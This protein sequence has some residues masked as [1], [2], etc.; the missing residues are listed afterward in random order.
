MNLFKLKINTEDLGYTMVDNVF[1]NHYMPKAPGDYV[2]VY[3][4]GLKFAV[5]STEDEISN[6]MVSKTLGM[7][8]EAVLGAW[9]YWD[10]Q[11]IIRLHRFNP[12]ALNSSDT[13]YIVEYL[14]LKELVP[15]IKEQAKVD[16]YSPD[17][18]INARQNLKTKE[19]FDYIRKIS[20]RELSQSE[21]FTFLDWIDDYNLPPEL[22]IMIIEDCFSRNKKDL[23]YLKQVAK[24][25]FDAGINSMEKASEYISRHK[26]K[27]QRYSKVLNF[28][29]LGRQPTSIEEDMLYKWFYTYNFSD[30]VVQK[31]CE[32][33]SKTLK[34]SFHFIDTILNE[35]FDKGFKVLEEVERHIESKKDSTKKA[36]VGTK[37]VNSQKPTFNNFAN[38]KYDTKQLKDML[39][40]KSRGE[41]SE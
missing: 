39:L 12:A 13:G 8:K 22:V 6:D 14:S 4:W 41:L 40:K 3:L 24:N 20:G 7:S 25:W 11:G 38:R 26:E 10:E 21:I 30:E 33:T 2:K 32:L 23:P 29:R 27:W 28:L 9:S 1:I 31:A 18:I 34:P 37:P 15:N 5:S 19:M 16:K 17:R 36:K 35:W